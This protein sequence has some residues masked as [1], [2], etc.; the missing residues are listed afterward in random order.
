VSA[1]ADPRFA[2]LIDE[3]F[4]DGLS[5]RSER[6]LRDHLRDCPACRDYYD[7]V[8]ALERGLS[9]SDHAARLADGF[10]AERAPRASRPR[11]IAAALP[12]LAALAIA[13][14]VLAPRLRPPG[15]TWHSR[16]AGAARAA[17]LR[18][19]CLEVRGGEARVLGSLPSSADAAGVLACPR[20]GA[21]QLA[22]TLDGGPP[23][24]LTIVGR[25]A[26]DRIA[27][28]LEDA[29]L[30]PGAVDAP[31]A[32]TVPLSDHAKG[33]LR[34]YALFSTRPITAADIPPLVLA[35]DSARLRALADVQQLVIEVGP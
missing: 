9:P 32:A 12:A 35:G 33:H 15:G 16:G 10:F 13:A 19:F 4:V 23:R 26:D 22:Y 18:A 1:C 2:E 24:R 14:V 20:D 3:L 28:L 27:T 5:R 17:G 21:V 30:T 8:V 29:P 7:R 6:R 34:L 31:I 11:W 25:D